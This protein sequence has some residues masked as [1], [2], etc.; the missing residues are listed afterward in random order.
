MIKVFKKHQ[1]F[2]Y[3]GYF[4]LIFTILMIYYVL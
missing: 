1:L 4:C 2:S 3:D